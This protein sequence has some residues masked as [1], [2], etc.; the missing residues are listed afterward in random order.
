LSDGSSNCTERSVQLHRSI[1]HHSDLMDP[2]VERAPAKINLVLRVG[3][4]RADGYH[5]VFSLMTRVDVADSLTLARAARTVVECPG[6]EGGDTLVTRALAGF[7]AAVGTDR[8]PGGFHVVVAKE[9]PAGAG[10]GG[11]SSDAAAALRGANRLCG[12]PLGADELSAIA[13]TIGSDVPFFLGPAVAIARGRGVQ[14]APGPALPPVAVVLAHPGRPLATR[15]VYE[16]YR[17][18]GPIATEALPDAIPSLA[19]L[20]SLVANDL[21]PVAEQLEPACRAL[22]LELLARGAA[23]AC[24]SGSGS[25][26][27]GLFRD[28]AD[29][30]SAATALPGA[31][32]ARAATLSSS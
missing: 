20:A 32:W 25:A 18:A 30:A 21:G 17:A 1:Q 13:A 22:R 3:P 2:I 4:R 7:V 14:L 10:L 16:A 27:F 28:L 6:L 5:E 19:A 26:V 11:G 8:V 29:A 15:D 12:L 31:A 24:V 9:I 23:A